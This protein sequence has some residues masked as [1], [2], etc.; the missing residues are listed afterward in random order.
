MRVTAIGK[1]SPA[2]ILV[3]TLDE[4]ADDWTTFT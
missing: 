4:L 2:K 3:L 1:R